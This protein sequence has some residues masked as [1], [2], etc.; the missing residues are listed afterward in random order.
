MWGNPRLVPLGKRSAVICR[1]AVSPSEGQW[2]GLPISIGHPGRAEPMCAQEL[3]RFV[4]GLQESVAYGL[5]FG[6]LE[7]EGRELDPSPF[8]RKFKN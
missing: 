7:L 6:P 3:L 1:L 8:V 5:C 4:G 2:D